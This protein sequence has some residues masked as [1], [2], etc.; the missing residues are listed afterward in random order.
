MLLVIDVGNTNIVLG[1]YEGENLVNCWRMATGGNRTADE[2]GIFIHGLFDAS[3]LDAKNVKAAIISSVVPDIMYSLTQ[4]IRKYFH[5]EPMIVSVGM[6]TG[7]VVKRDNPK[8]VGADRIVNLVAANEIYGGPAVV[9]DYGTANTFDVINEKSEFI[10]GFISPGISSC[11]DALYQKAAQ[12]PKI[13]IKQ[14]KSIIA[15]NTVD[16][17]QAGLVLGHMGQTR[18]IVEQL[19]EE[20]NLPD[21]KV[22]ATGGLARVVDPDNE[23]FDVLDPVLTLKGLRILYEKNK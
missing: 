22:I 1:V 5:I 9:I 7:I 15:K 10:T 21:M 17:L 16:S 14:P 12:L 23:V 8:A 6:K 4:G 19:K 13:E 11:A 2:T 3:G 18:Y 20:L